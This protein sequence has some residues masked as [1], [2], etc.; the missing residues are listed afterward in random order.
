MSIV[1]DC[2]ENN[3]IDECKN[4]LGEKY[5][6]LIEIK[7]LP[8]GDIIIDDIIIERKTLTDLAS[9][10]V[11][12]RYKEQGKRLEDAFNNGYKVYYF[13]EG[14]LNNYNHKT[15]KKETLMSCIYSL[16][17]EKNMNVIMTHNIKETTQFILQFRKKKIINENNKNENNK[18]E[19][20]KNVINKQKNKNITKDNIGEYMLCQIPNISKVNCDIIFNKFGNMNNFICMLNKD[21]RLLEDLIYVK[22]NKEKKLNKNVIESLNHYLRI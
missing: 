1:I 8:L 6:E 18:N 20:N 5:D 17:Y 22:D 16:T 14:N 2:R 7:Q 11:D 4:I 19:N 3:I 13:I 15:I 9:S 21:E 10:I 12:G